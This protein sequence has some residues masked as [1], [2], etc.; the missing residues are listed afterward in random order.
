V[1]TPRACCAQAEERGNSSRNIK[2]RLANN[3]RSPATSGL[4]LARAVDE[5]KSVQAYR[6]GRKHLV[7]FDDV[8]IF[9]PVERQLDGT[10]VAI[11]YIIRGANRK[12]FLDIHREIRAFQTSPVKPANGMPSAFRFMMS[13]PLADAPAIH[14]TDPR[15]QPP[16]SHP[17]GHC[18]RHGW[19]DSG[20]H[21]RSWRRLGLAQ[22][23]NPSC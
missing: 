19:C 18:R 6:K 7:I 12:S 4:C 15:R 14:P 21:G 3:C 11:P 16:R 1:G 23:G 13:T 8:D 10:A 20:R 2:H 9:L 22:A 5:D 17:P